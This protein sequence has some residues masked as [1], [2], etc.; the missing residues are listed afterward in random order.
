[1]D[2]TYDAEGL[3]AMIAA[4]ADV[5]LGKGLL[6]AA[7]G[8]G[9]LEMVQALVEGGV[10]LLLIETCFDTGNLKAGLVAVQKLRRDL[11]IAIPVIA[12]GGAP[13]SPLLKC[14]AT[15]Q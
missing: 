10:D 9:H 2:P 8:R 14:S 5:N 15:G 6:G 1:M 4:G 7:A 11:G 3:R 12:S 13:A